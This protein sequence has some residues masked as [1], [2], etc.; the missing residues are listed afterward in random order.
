MQA[1]AGSSACEGRLF[2]GRGG[3]EIGICRVAMSE[4]QHLATYCYAP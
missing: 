4:M 3:K 1:I 2:D